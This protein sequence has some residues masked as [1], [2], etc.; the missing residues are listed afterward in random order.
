M[1]KEVKKEAKIDTRTYI[2]VKVDS[3]TSI[4][5]YSIKSRILSK[6]I[7]KLVD[8]DYLLRT[9]RNRKKF[10]AELKESRKMFQAIGK[11]VQMDEPTDIV[12][13]TELQ[14]EFAKTMETIRLFNEAKD[15]EEIRLKDLGE[16]KDRD[17]TVLPD[18]ELKL[19]EVENENK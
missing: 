17:N 13:D 6:C 2:H 14:E 15:T 4:G 18:S 11:A 7:E 9:G 5:T 8:L 16:D 3:I 19:K 12:V 10:E 1:G